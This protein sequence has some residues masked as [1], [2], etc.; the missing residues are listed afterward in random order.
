MLNNEIWILKVLFLLLRFEWWLGSLG[1][2]NIGHRI[3][4]SHIEGGLFRDK[5]CV[6]EGILRLRQHR[7]WGECLR[8]QVLRS[9]GGGLWAERV[10]LLLG[11]ILNEC[12]FPFGEHWLWY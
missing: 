10:R 2:W 7:Y 3:C 12:V 5:I 4:W 8:E 6:P 11:L 9:E 1:H